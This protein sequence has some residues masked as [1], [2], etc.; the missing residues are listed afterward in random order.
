[1]AERPPEM[2]VTVDAFRSI[3]GASPGEV[4]GLIRARQIVLRDG[5]VPL[6]SGVRAFLDRIRATTRNARLTAAQTEARAARA[7]ASELALDIET[8]KLV[9]DAAGDEATTSIAGTI[10]H[11]FASLPAI[12]TRDVRERRAIEN[13][14]HNAQTAL[15][16][17]IATAE[18]V[19]PSEPAK[20]TPTTKG[21]TA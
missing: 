7:E 21:R 16:D 8:G 12:A 3:C 10:L 2:L 15:A 11:E 14:L 18:P 19:L 1:M 9:P 5:Q 13:L 20:S 4:E 17:A 6:V